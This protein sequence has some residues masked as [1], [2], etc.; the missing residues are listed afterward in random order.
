MSHN[1]WFPASSRA[2][3]LRSSVSGWTTSTSSS[4][5]VPTSPV[6]AYFE[7]CILVQRRVA[8]T[9]APP[10]PMEEIVRAFNWVIEKGWVSL[11][12]L[13]RPASPADKLACAGVLLGHV[14]VV[15]VPDR[16]GAP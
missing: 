9:R 14:G 1:A 10:V 16:G 3:K 2:Q 6:R 8:N 12:C 4:P 5:T 11:V 7:P 15:G 13:P